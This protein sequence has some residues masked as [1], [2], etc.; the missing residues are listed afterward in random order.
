ME[1]AAR[2]TKSA[3]ADSENSKSFES[4]EAGFVYVAAVSFAKQSA[5]RTRK[6]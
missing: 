4:A 1:F 6:A 3:V 2:Q 5:L